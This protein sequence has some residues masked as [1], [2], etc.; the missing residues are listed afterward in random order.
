MDNFAFL[1]ELVL[2][3]KNKIEQ[4]FMGFEKLMI[5]SISLERGRDNPQLIFESINS[6]GKNLTQI[7]LIRNY[8]LMGLES[9]EQN[10]LYEKYWRK[11][12]LLFE[13][14]SFESLFNA[15]M[16]HYLTL[17]TREIP[18][19]SKVYEAF[20]DY[21][22]DR[23][24]EIEVLLQDVEKYCNYFCFIAFKK[25]QDKDLKKAF[26]SF[27]ELG[28]DTAYPLLLELYNDYTNKVLS[29]K[30][31][32]NIIT[33]IESYVFRRA[34]CEISTNSLNKT[35]ASFSKNLKK[36]K[37]LESIQAHFLLLK[38]YTRFPSDDEFKEALMK[39]DFYHFA[40]KT[41]CIKKLENHKRKEEVSID[42][43]TIEHN[44][45]CLKI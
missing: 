22:I 43:Y 31:F 44:T 27:L 37:Y 16:R 9:K 32:I 10:R 1:K 15:F 11:M 14:N 36:E 3:N 38:S 13:Q 41:Y 2:K 35:F 21:H 8:I 6:T 39:K 34:V 4:I 25:E 26:E 30:D 18:N 33:I 23:D 29:K 12:E 20:K 5:V 24:L 42:E 17:K 19:I 7:D 45:L 28:A 40:K